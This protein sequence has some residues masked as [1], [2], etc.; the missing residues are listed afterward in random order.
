MVV[1]L[2]EDT[3]A[4]LWTV[5]GLVQDRRISAVPG[6]PVTLGKMLIVVAARP[7]GEHLAYREPMSSDC[8]DRD[9]AGRWDRERLIGG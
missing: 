2:T 4:H 6:H 5:P 9:R 3:P 1:R 8:E 7:H